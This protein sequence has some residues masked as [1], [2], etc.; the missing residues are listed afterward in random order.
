MALLS[1]KSRTISTRFDGVVGAQR[2]AFGFYLS[3]RSVRR[4]YDLINH[5]IISIYGHR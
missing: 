5:I 3:N 2:S 1:G 4:I